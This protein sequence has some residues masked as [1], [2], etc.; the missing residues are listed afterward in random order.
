MNS[1]TVHIRDGAEEVKVIPNEGAADGDREAV[2]ACGGLG[3]RLEGWVE[4]QEERE[5]GLFA[6]VEGRK[7]SA[8]R[9]S[10]LPW[11]EENP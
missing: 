3:V 9:P 7:A 8:S 1:S 10:S 5:E 11:G 6:V 2:R 4:G